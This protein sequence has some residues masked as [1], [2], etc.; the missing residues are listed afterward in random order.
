MAAVAG[1]LTS[2]RVERFGV[3]RRP[4][5]P[6]GSRSAVGIT[7]HSGGAFTV[8]ETIVTMEGWV[9]NTRTFTA[10]AAAWNDCLFFSQRIDDDSGGVNRRGGEIPLLEGENEVGVRS[11]ISWLR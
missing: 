11:R 1:T 3:S 9:R 7:R 10:E 5:P 4:R 8:V 2:Y 6:S